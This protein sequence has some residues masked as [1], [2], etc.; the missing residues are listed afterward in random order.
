[1]CLWAVALFAAQPSPAAWK[2]LFD[3]RDLK[4]WDTSRSQGMTRNGKWTVEDGVLVGAWDPA[5]PGA[6]WLLTEADYGDFRL[7]LKFWASRGT[8]SGVAIR[9]ASHGAKNPA[10]AGYEIQIKSQDKDFKNP[11]GSIYDLVAA[12]GGKIREL[13]WNGLEIR[14]K[15]PAITVL[16][17]GEK[18]AEANDSR[19]SRGA[20]GFQ[21]HGRTPHHDIIKFKD[22]LIDA[23]E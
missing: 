23:D 19:S 6:G 21:I 12:P 8:N 10:F 13:E 11:T 5:H 4:G 20:I 7:K 17:N 16:L 1:M 14:C 15:G 18:V 9:D 3:G 2:P 22:V